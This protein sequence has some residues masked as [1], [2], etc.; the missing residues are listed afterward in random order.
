MDSPKTTRRGLNEKSIEEIPRRGLGHSQTLQR[1][2]EGRPSGPLSNNTVVELSGPGRSARFVS[3]Q[4]GPDD[5]SSTSCRSH[6][7]DSVEEGVAVMSA[8]KYRY[9]VVLP[10]Q[11][12]HPS[13]RTS[14]HSEDPP[15]WTT[16]A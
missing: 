11:Y 10:Y 12:V 1:A 3:H 4:D 8:A 13:S 7:L 9:A 16:A 5:L 15:R 14:S 2:S 6:Q